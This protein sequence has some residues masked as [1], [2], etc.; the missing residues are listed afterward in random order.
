MKGKRIA[1]L[2]IFALVL[3]GLLAQTALAGSQTIQGITFNGPDTRAQCVDA[4]SH[5]TITITGLTGHKPAASV[6]GTVDV[7]YVING[8]AGRQEI[9]TYNVNSTKDVTLN[10]SYPPVS[11]WPPNGDPNAHEIH[12]DV[13]IKVLVGGQVVGEFDGNPNLGWD[14]F[15]T[16]KI[17][18]P[19]STK[20]SVGQTKTPTRTA[21]VLVQ[22]GHTATPTATPKP[23]SPNDNNTSTPAPQGETVAPTATPAGPTPAVLPTTGGTADAS[24]SALAMIMLFGLGLLGVGWALKRVAK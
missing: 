13:A 4:T 5:D 8:G 15:C 1:F 16:S 14:V 7:Q 3:T 2:I 11:Q 17:I 22:Q 23:G 9:K 20:V 10:V 21:T 24:M 19:T 12:V 18:T 6:Q